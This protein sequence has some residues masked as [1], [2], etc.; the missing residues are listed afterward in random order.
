MK[1]MTIA[2][3][4]CGTAGMILM[5]VGASNASSLDEL[6]SWPEVRIGNSGGFFIRMQ[7]SQN[8]AVRLPADLQ[9]QDELQ[10]AREDLYAKHQYKIDSDPS[11]IEIEADRGDLRV[12]KTDGSQLLLTTENLP[13]KGTVQNGRQI[14]WK[15]E[16]QTLKVKV[17]DNTHHLAKSSSEQPLLILSVPAKLENLNLETSL[18]QISLDRIEAARCSLATSLGHVRMQAA[19][20]DS[21]SA[22]T[23]LGD[24]GIAS[25]KTG[26][27]AFETSMGDIEI[28]DS[29][30]FSEL[31]A[32]TALGDLEIILPSGSGQ[33]D[34]AGADVNL[35][36]SHGQISFE[37]A[38]VQ[39]ENGISTFTRANPG[40]SLVIRLET[41]SGNI[42]LAQ[43]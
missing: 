33:S 5:G 34:L 8:E 25:G 15:V 21:V 14:S 27:G 24:I 42:S 20:L 22:Y 19:K 39:S 11:V 10:N 6:A 31:E 23:A 12:E 37:E 7:T 30:F 36:T 17:E 32:S 35:Q 13:E 3:L 38:P 26:K 9:S 4:C 18:G 41:A 43:K 16:N 40:A 28:D 1:K 2:A 29:V